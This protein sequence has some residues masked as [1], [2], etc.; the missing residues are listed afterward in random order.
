MSVSESLSSGKIAQAFS[1]RLRLA[2]SA[3]LALAGSLLRAEELLTPGGSLPE[4]AEELDLLARIHVQQRRYAEAHKRW[5]EALRVSG[6]KS[7]Y[8]DALDS[9]NAYVTV[10]QR[11]R[12]ILLFAASIVI[13]ILT[14]VLAFILMGRV[15][16]L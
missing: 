7:S 10:L 4:T 9:L 15:T 8:Q 14:T 2:R 5:K 12:R 13:L 16:H 3:E 1:L 6:G 11:R